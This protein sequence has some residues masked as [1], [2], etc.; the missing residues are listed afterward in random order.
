[1]KPA[2]GA[3]FTWAAGTNRP[4]TEKSVCALA[5]AGSITVNP[6]PTDAELLQRYVSQ[7]DERAFAELVAG[8]F[9]GR[10]G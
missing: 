10:R 9:A 3:G 7:R 2:R 4:A 6:M 1:M 5:P 8:C